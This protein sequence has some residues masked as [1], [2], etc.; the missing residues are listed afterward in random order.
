MDISLIKLVVES[1]LSTCLASSNNTKY[2][3]NTIEAYTKTSAHLAIQNIDQILSNIP[4]KAVKTK[5]H[6]QTHK[7]TKKCSALNFCFLDIS[8]VKTKIT[9]PEIIKKNCNKFIL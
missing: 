5:S 9:I 7:K 3:K 2:S 6:T 8:I 4:G 1:L